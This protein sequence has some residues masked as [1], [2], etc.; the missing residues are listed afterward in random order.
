MKIILS[1]I[2]VMCGTTGCVSIKKK[3]NDD[4]NFLCALCI[5]ST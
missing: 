2:G 1:V 5:I 3:Y 4:G